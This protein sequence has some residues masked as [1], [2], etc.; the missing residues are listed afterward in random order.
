[1]MR[2]AIPIFIT[3]MVFCSPASAA[4]AEVNCQAE[5]DP[6]CF[7]IESVAAALSTTQ[8][9]DHPDV[10]FDVSIK[11]DPTSKPNVFGLRDSFSPVRNIRFNLPPGLIGDPNV[12]GTPQQC[13]TQELVGSFGCPNASQVGIST[14]A[15]Y[16]PNANFKLPEPVYMMQPPGGDVV[17]RLG[18][19]AAVYPT[20][21]DV[22]IRSEDDYGIVA[23]VH[24]AS[25]VAK[26]VTLETALWG[27]PAD[28]SHNEERCTPKEVF[29][30][31]ACVKSESRPPGGR[32][33]PF[34]T[35]PT[36]CG[37]SL[38]MGVNASSWAEEGF[39]PG[40]EVSAKFP[41]ITGCD[42]LPFGP[43]LSVEPTS[44]RADSPTGLD[45]TLRLPAS[46]GV[47]VLEPAQMRNIKITL[48]AGLA[49]NPAVGEGL[50]TCS[51][52]QLHFKQRV[53]SE[54]PNA[55]KLADTEFD[56]PV[57]PRRMKGAIYLREP[58]P[59]NPYRIW[60][61]ADD[62]GAHVK[63]PG[64]LNVD[65]SSGQIESVV[66]D[67][68]QAP[69]REVKLL[70]K[71]GFRAPL[72]DPPSCGSFFTHYEFTPWSDG[73]PSVGETQMT[74]DEGC[75]G[76][77][78]FSPELSAGSIDSS[79]GKH[80][81]FLFTL[82]REDGE[83]NPASLEVT[84]PR[85]IAA[86]FTGVGRC[87]GL[88]AETGACPADSRI[89]KVIA[90]VGAGAAPLWVPQP[91]KRPSAVYLSGPYRGAPLS[92]VTVVPRQAG[93]FDFGD[94][95]VRAAIAVNPV[96]A[97]ATAKTD[98]LP[99]IIEGIPI[100][101]RTIHV[102]LDRPG[103]VLN[104]TSCAHQE[105]EAAVI[106]SL[107]A[108]ARPSSPYGATN[109]AKLGFGPKLGIRLLGGTH[110]GAHPKLVA[111]LQMP[112]GSANIDSTSVTLPPSEFIENSHFKTICT[113]VQFV[114]KSC[115]AGSIYGYAVAKTPLLDQPLKGPAYL[116]SS[117]HALPDL[118]LALK[119]PPS[120]PIEVDLAGRVDT[121]DGG[122]RTT[123]ATVPD[124]PVSEFTLRMQG[125]KKSLIVNST[126]LCASTNR[127]NV[128]F[129]GQ[130]G[131]TRQQR[132]AVEATAC[133]KKKRRAGSH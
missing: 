6:S 61:V 124:A 100:R 25:P 113:R 22:R 111:R 128:Q 96:T 11:Q 30:T 10:H 43:R 16:Q 56:I 98:P 92:I 32:A 68:P 2:R 15:V 46:D 65:R 4:K 127:A 34:M 79:G 102:E 39:D 58:E 112:A 38:S 69:L 133:S 23:E 13:T 116:R 88:A 77:G 20:F 97:R 101:Y 48:P 27:V 91:G 41:T 122:L 93:P 40:K 84:L 19:V 75:V 99:Q 115:P 45:I 114:A 9:G 7:G 108:V 126:N 59:G 125:G 31:A 14:L 95:V 130:N 117:N 66:L 89:G 72:V 35:N 55:A 78:A 37:Q 33:L 44:H 82:T 121:I 81:P 21:I 87:L 36:R 119:G 54:C 110:R 105:T 80:S 104:P 53:A 8:A 24:E 129:T 74:I 132:T 51:A 86:T 94:E 70:F 85:G 42:K 57:L 106:S 26:L 1:M 107:G 5:S 18:L 62:L 118:V 12:L 76:L 63:L 3:A 131:K 123:F 109:C 73:P 47:K 120:L 67:A 60:I 103:F 50:A 49:I 29:G 28:S 17:A 83:Q 90:A 52:D 71:S 64:Q